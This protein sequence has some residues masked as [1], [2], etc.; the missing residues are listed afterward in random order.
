MSLDHSK[1][2]SVI[3]KDLSTEDGTD[4][5]AVSTPRSDSH[6]SINR[7]QSGLVRKISS[8]SSSS[9]GKNSVASPGTSYHTLPKSQPLNDSITS[10]ISAISKDS[11]VKISGGHSDWNEPKVQFMGSTRRKS[12]PKNEEKNSS[13]TEL[14]AETWADILQ[15]ENCLPKDIRNL[16]RPDLSV[17]PIS[18]VNTT[19][20]TMPLS[21][22]TPRPNQTDMIDVSG[23]A[24]STPYSG[25]RTPSILRSTTSISSSNKSV[26]FGDDVAFKQISPD[27]ES[28]DWSL[29][30]SETDNLTKILLQR[31]VQAEGKLNK[32]DTAVQNDKKNEPGPSGIDRIKTNE[33]LNSHESFE[34]ISASINEK[35]NILDKLSESEISE[36][37]PKESTKLSSANNSHTESIKQLS[38]ISSSNSSSKTLLAD[39]SQPKPNPIALMPNM[40]FGVQQSPVRL[41]KEDLSE[42]EDLTSSFEQTNS[43]LS[44]ST[45]LEITNQVVEWA[46]ERG[47]AAVQKEGSLSKNTTLSQSTNSTGIDD[48]VEK[49]ADWYIENGNSRVTSSSNV[50]EAQQRESDNTIDRILSSEDSTNNAFDTLNHS[51]NQSLSTS[52]NSFIQHELEMAHEETVAADEIE[53]SPVPKMS[54]EQLLKEVTELHKSFEEDKTVDRLQD[55]HDSTSFQ[56]LDQI[57]SPAVEDQLASNSGVSQSVEVELFEALTKEVSSE[58]SSFPE[59]QEN[60]DEQASVENENQISEESSSADVT[61]RPPAGPISIQEAFQRRKKKFIENSKKRQEAVKGKISFPYALQYKRQFI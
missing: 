13:A 55:S 19:A 5:R 1:E 52:M 22:D 25:S 21:L 18:S 12:I 16:S 35:L 42:L 8:K 46:I 50:Q 7:S 3:I 56:A 39:K 32:L 44:K 26:T 34:N 45:S 6:V 43:T 4:V 38:S 14:I 60:T 41:S 23:P 2:S 28:S 31:L 47:L 61:P 51:K 27:P 10:T 30:A 54:A 53:A 57:E 37:T 36:D 40:E 58:R 33:S 20:N 15:R 29:S 11:P 17:T 49:L 48:I 59:N 24:Q 9:Y